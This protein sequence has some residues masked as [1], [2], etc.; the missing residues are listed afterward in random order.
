MANYI[1]VRIV[2]KENKNQVTCETGGKFSNLGILQDLHMTF[3]ISIV[4]TFSTT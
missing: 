1:V 2:G 3:S 4:S